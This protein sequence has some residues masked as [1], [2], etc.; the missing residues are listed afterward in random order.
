M[1]LVSRD[2][3]RHGARNGLRVGGWSYKSLREDKQVPDP[4]CPR[5]GAELSV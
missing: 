4:G 1:E 2:I 5:T 3:Q